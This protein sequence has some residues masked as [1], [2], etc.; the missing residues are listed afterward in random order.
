MRTFQILY[1]LE[2]NIAKFPAQLD[3]Y[4]LKILSVSP[5][6][7]ARLSLTLYSI[8][9]SLLCFIRWCA[10]Q[11]ESL[12]Q[13]TFS[14]SSILIWYFIITHV[15]IIQQWDCDDS[16]EHT[17][18][19]HQRL[20]WWKNGAAENC[21]QGNEEVFLS[22]HFSWWFE[23]P[24]QRSESLCMIFCCGQYHEQIWWGNCLS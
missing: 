20:C 7:P 10:L 19:K 6:P 15:G 3:A 17:P 23:S 1:F 16:H 11:E 18:G 2:V 4:N 13:P 8:L 9:S 24:G 5:G 21:F 14:C 12:L 22:S